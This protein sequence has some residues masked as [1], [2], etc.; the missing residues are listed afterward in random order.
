MNP[1]FYHSLLTHSPLQWATWDVGGM[2][3]S[4]GLS[5]GY[6]IQGQDA[7]D[8]GSLLLAPSVI[9]SQSSIFPSMTWEQSPA[10]LPPPPARMEG[11]RRTQDHWM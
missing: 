7:L 10:L 3:G 9:Y 1:I 5:S 11:G 4:S 2:Q 8:F 6:Y